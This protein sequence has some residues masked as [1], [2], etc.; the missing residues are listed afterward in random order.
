MSSKRYFW[1]PEY[2]FIDKLEEMMNI[3]SVEPEMQLVVV[4]ATS[5]LP[6]PKMINLNCGVEAV[7]GVAA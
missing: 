4:S 2:M 3:Q 6:L 5:A 1:Y 7:F